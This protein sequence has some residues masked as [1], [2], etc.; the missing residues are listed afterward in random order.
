[1]R[2]LYALTLALTSIRCIE[3]LLHDSV[4]LEHMFDVA[5]KPLTK[6]FFES[7]FTDMNQRKSAITVTERLLTL[8]TDL[9]MVYQ[10][11]FPELWDVFRRFRATKPS[12]VIL[13]KESGTR[14][15]EEHDF[16]GL[17]LIMHN[18]ER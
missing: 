8:W 6:G 2:L 9:T 12:A 16:D 17:R 7:M 13:A 5:S 3:R 4:L 14:P 10:H 18:F 15:V 1:M 11:E